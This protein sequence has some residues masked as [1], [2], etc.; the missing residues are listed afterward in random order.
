MI[1]QIYDKNNNRAS[2]FFLFGRQWILD[3]IGRVGTAK[4][5]TIF[6]YNHDSVMFPYNYWGIQ[7]SARGNIVAFVIENIKGKDSFLTNFSPSALS[8]GSY[9]NSVTTRLQGLGRLKFGGKTCVGIFEYPLPFPSHANGSVTLTNQSWYTT[10]NATP[11]LSHQPKGICY[12]NP[13]SRVEN[14]GG[15]TKMRSLDRITWVTN[16]TRY[17]LPRWA[18]HQATQGQQELYIRASYI[19]ARDSLVNFP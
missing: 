3:N 16:F 7:Y 1:Y 13:C 15:M 2:R 14:N 9:P 6:I 4:W 10:R 19:L 11:I 8:G 18:L 5:A 12:T 17:L